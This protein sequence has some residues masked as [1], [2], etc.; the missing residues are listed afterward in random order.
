MALVKPPSFC[1]N[2]GEKQPMEGPSLFHSFP[3]PISISVTLSFKQVIKMN[4]LTKKV[5]ESV[6]I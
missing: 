3:L 5:F 2:W 6:V 1:G 4:K